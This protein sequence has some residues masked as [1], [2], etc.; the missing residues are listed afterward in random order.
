MRSILLQRRR[1]DVARMDFLAAGALH[2]QHGRLEHAPEGQR[3]FGLLLLAA[4][5]LLDRIL[6]VLV[7]IAPQLRHVGATGGEDALAVG[8]V[9]Q[10]VQQ[11]LERQVR[12]T[13]RGGLAVGD[14]EN[15]FKSGT[16]H[17]LVCRGAPPPRPVVASLRS[18]RYYQPRGA[19]SYDSDSVI[20]V[21]LPNASYGSSDQCCPCCPCCPWPY[22]WIRVVGGPYSGSMAASNGNP[23]SRAR[24]MTVATFVS[25][26]SCG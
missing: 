22:S 6:E 8:V 24:S 20:P 23:L 1:D 18:R 21:R 3:L 13:P 5:E 7:E 12:V 9:R 15:N 10:R 2:V 4:R 19:F 11:V 16:E 26:T 25:A 17:F 14:G